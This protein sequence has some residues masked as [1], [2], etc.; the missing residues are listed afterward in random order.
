[1]IVQMLQF[2]TVHKFEEPF[3]PREQMNVVQRNLKSSFPSAIQ[4]G[5]F[6]GRLVALDLIP[7]L[8]SS[9]LDI[10]V[11]VF[12]IFKILSILHTGVFLFSQLD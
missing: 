9:N 3:R 4:R 11:G 5:C 12:R 6:L 1:M 7:S 8:Y 2:G 10:V